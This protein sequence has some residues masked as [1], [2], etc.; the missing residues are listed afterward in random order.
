VVRRIG[1][2]LKAWNK[3]IY[4]VVKWTLFGGIAFAVFWR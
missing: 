3:S 2:R 1:K 4:Y